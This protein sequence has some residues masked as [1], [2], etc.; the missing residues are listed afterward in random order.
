[1]GWRKDG[2]TLCNRHLADPRARAKAALRAEVWKVMGFRRGEV[3]DLN[4]I[5]L[6]K[7]MIGQA[8][9]RADGYATEIERLLVETPTLRDVL[10]GDVEGEF[11]KAGEYIR[12][13]A[14]LENEERDRVMNW[15]FKA[16][17]VGLAARE[18]DAGLD[19]ARQKELGLVEVLQAFMAHPDMALS[20][21]Q[22][23]VAPGVLRQV[24]GLSGPLTIEGSS[25]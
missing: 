4:L 24:L 8:R 11:G 17:A 14:R 2:S 5:Q 18:I 6:T 1:M 22:R 13:I 25:G 7:D 16:L 19:A 20:A 21:T 9:D 23:S 12:G 10:V 15:T 3:T